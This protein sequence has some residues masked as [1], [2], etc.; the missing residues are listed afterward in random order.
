M[1]TYREESTMLTWNVETVHVY[2]HD[3][4]RIG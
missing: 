4:I 1:I 2:L 3:A